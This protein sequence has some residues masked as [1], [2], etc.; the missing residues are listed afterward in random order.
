MRHRWWVNALKA[1]VLCLFP[2]WAESVKHVPETEGLTYRTICSLFLRGA[3]GARCLSNL[4]NI[5]ITP[6]NMLTSVGVATDDDGGGRSGESSFKTS[7]IALG[8]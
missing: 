3:R 8:R 2:V 1:T 4:S 6:T 5:I 7:D